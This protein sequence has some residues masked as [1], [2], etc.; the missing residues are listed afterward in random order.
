MTRGPQEAAEIVYERLLAQGRPEEQARRDAERWVLG[1]FGIAVK[2]QEPQPIVDEYQAATGVVFESVFGD[3]QVTVTMGYDFGV[4][5]TT[6][7]WSG[8]WQ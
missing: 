4:T 6:G 1:N 3:G 8:G 2:L 7:V 5:S